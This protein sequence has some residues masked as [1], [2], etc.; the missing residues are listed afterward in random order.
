MVLA[1]VILL[2]I[3]ASVYAYRLTHFYTDSSLRTPQR[4]ANLLARTWRIFT[5]PRFVK[6]APGPEPKFAFDETG[7]VLSNGLRISGWYARPDTLHRGTVIMFHGVGSQKSDL[8]YEASAFRSLGLRVLM[9][10]LRG[11]GRSEGNRTTL[12]VKEAEEVKL[13]WDLVSAK[14]EKN[15]YLYGVSMG[16]VAVSRAIWKYGMEPA[17]VILEMPF[18]S[19]QTH[20]RARARTLGFPGFPEK[21][22]S[23]L[24]SRWIGWES[25]F[26][27]LAH[28]STKY[29]REIDCPVLL[30]W[31]ERDKLVTKAEIG[32][33]YDAI[34]TRNK[35]L[36]TYQGA[37]HES[38]Y[39]S[40]P[41]T[42]KR[43]VEGILR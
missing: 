5:G 7:L 26:S 9:I 20:L 35:K 4:S 2:N 12:G 27:G 8:L 32:D 38:L 31:G 37:G 6:A 36:V 43:A 19:L 14:G 21:P 23:F 39:R 22:F 16:A 15:I 42:W 29:V 25:G 34:G 1:Q 33:I 41:E 40:D 18:A 30:Q 3:S 10:D 28:R 11:H 17:A 13:A 24:V